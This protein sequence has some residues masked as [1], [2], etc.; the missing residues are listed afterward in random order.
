VCGEE[1][2]FGLAAGWLAKRSEG[3]LAPMTM[4]ATFNLTA[5]LTVLGITSILNR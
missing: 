5:A 1:F 3:L 4:H 2:L